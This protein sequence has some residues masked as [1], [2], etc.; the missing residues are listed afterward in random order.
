M[1]KSFF[2]VLL[3]ALVVVTDARQCFLRIRRE[4]SS[5]CCAR[6]GHF[7]CQVNNGVIGP[8]TPCDPDGSRTGTRSWVVCE[9]TGCTSA[10]RCGC[11]YC[12]PLD[13]IGAAAVDYDL[14]KKSLYFAAG[15]TDTFSNTFNCAYIPGFRPGCG[16]IKRPRDLTLLVD[17]NDYVPVGSGK[18]CVR[19][20]QCCGGERCKRVR[21]GPIITK[22]CRV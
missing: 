3:L 20:L 15:E 17:C 5:N 13:R 4:S 21:I 22:R 7:G 6:C 10:D 18:S 19:N 9:G 12:K 11:C 2:L 1:F 8:N 14:S 16:E